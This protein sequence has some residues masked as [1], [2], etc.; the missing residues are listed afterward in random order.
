MGDGSRPVHAGPPSDHLADAAERDVCLLYRRLAEASPFLGRPAPYL[1]QLDFSGLFVLPYWECLDLAGIDPRRRAFLREG[2]LV[3]ILQMAFD[4]M[5]TGSPCR[6]RLPLCREAVAGLEAGGERTRT[7]AEIVLC[8]IDAAVAGSGVGEALQEDSAWVVERHVH[9][10]FRRRERRLRSLLHFREDDPAGAKRAMA[11]W[12]ARRAGKAYARL[13]RA[14]SG[15]EAA[16]AYA[17]CAESLEEAADLARELGLD[18]EAAELERKRSHC[19]DVYR[20][21]FGP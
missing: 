20:R 8:A 2:C 18:A 4:A 21:Q 9:A 12:L 16:E 13:Y 7:L 17:D 15:E 11:R 5:E 6:D 10:Y 19:A 14:A 3:M 1:E